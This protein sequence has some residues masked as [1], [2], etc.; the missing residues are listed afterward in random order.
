MTQD[1]RTAVEGWLCPVC[2]LIH[3]HKTVLEVDPGKRP[4]VRCPCPGCKVNNREW[5]TMEDYQDWLRRYMPAIEAEARDIAAR[6]TMPD[7]DAE[8][9]PEDREW[10]GE[11][12][13]MTEERK[14]LIAR[15][16]QDGTFERK[17]AFGKYG[18]PSD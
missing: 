12:E 18:P 3:R 2:D 6:G 10:H 4:A 9:T 13:E 17:S 7:P 14:W 1:E 11:F 15:Q 16:K 8:E 5:L